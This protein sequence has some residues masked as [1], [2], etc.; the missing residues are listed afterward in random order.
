MRKRTPL[1]LLGCAVWLTMTSFLAAADEKYVAPS[2]DTVRDQAMAYA[3]QQ[4][5]STENLKAINQL[6][7]G[8]D[9]SAS[10]QEL[11]DVAV[12][13]FAL[14]NPDIQAFVEACQLS[15]TPTLLPETKVLDSRENEFV[16]ANLR[17]YF[18]R[19]LARGRMY[20]EALEQFS[21][22][23]PRNVID[24]AT[25]LFYTAVSQQQLLQKTE[26]L[27]TLDKLLTKTENVP[28]RY[29]SVAKLMQFEL[30]NLRQD[31]LDEVA[32]LMKD[33]ERRLDLGRGGR[34]VQK[35]EAEVIAALD[36]LIE[37]L[38]QQ[39]CN[40]SGSCPCNGNKPSNKNQASNPAKDSMIKGAT[41]PGNVDKKHVANKG[42][43]GSLPEKEQAAA[44]Q[45]AEKPYPPYYLKIIAEYNKK[46]AERKLK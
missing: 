1:F 43:W 39:N 2:F 21:Q 6:W 46:L 9:E 30:E 29:S 44:K 38:E 42:G 34:Q 36:Y 11:L 24:P 27:A 31:S 10:A 40:C 35:K 22:I 19:Y 25:S 32:A 13:S 15:L 3:K 5:V 28:V 7:S 45:Y 26:G 41:A 8:V 16:N 23:D 4:H 20:D 14:A 33:V 12:N 17:L 18:A 37:K